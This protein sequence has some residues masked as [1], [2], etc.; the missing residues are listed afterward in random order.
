M[1]V[2]YG[3]I[4]IFLLLSMFVASGIQPFRTL[5]SITLMDEEKN[6]LRNRRE[7]LL[8][9]SLTKREKTKIKI[10]SMLRILGKEIF[11]LYLMIIVFFI[12]GILVGNILFKN[13]YLNI[14][15]GIC[16]IPLVYIYLNLKTS[17][18]IK[19]EEEKLENTMSIITNAYISSDDIKK[20]FELY[21]DEERKSKVVRSSPFTDFL[22][23]VNYTNISTKSALTILGEK[24][25]N[26]YFKQWIKVL[27]I[28]EYNKNSK[29]ALKPIIDSMND[30]KLIRTEA[31]T[32]LAKIWREYFLTVAIMF[33]VI[34]IIN[35]AN[36]DWYYILTNTVG[37][38]FMITL[39]LLGA[40]IAT[41]YVQK[42]NKI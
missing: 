17:W 35:I 28:C 14:L 4:F 32:V 23:D 10:E 27:I 22:M 5:T 39:M 18:H 21:V 30:E 33:L 1:S 24:I 6:V 42:I 2:W 13:M 7:K 11:Y 25:N 15:T 12:G 31:D 37:G 16:A 41:F 34:P 20:S 8:E 29:F 40:L 3:F 38:K 19:A 26:S 36:A 9:K